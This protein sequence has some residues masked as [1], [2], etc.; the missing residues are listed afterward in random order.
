MD[1]TDNVKGAMQMLEVVP[2]RLALNDSRVNL[3][4]RIEDMDLTKALIFQVAQRAAQLLCLLANDVWTKVAVGSITIALL[5]QLLR[6]VKYNC[7]GKYMI[8]A[9]Q[10]Y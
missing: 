8:F 9:R 1:I 5:A 10:F 4:Y 2:Q 3:L 7:N 6:E